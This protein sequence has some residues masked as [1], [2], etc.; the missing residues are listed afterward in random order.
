M[1]KKVKCKTIYVLTGHGEKHKDNLNGIKP[2]FIAENL[3][4]AAK[5]ITGKNQ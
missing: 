2:D 5:I 3:Y 4:E 1:G